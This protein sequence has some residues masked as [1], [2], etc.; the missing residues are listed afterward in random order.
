MRPNRCPPQIYLLMSSHRPP[1]RFKIF[2]TGDHQVDR[3][4]LCWLK[5]SPEKPAAKR[6]NL[7]FPSTNIFLR[8]QL[9]AQIAMK[10]WIYNAWIP[11]TIGGN[12]SGK[13]VT[14]V[15]S[16]F[17]LHLKANFMKRRRH[18]LSVNGF[19]ILWKRKLCEV[20]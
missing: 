10:C 17:F 12:G 6:S 19:T 1:S 9:W 18:P 7:L 11:P 13:L 5:Q 20:Y 14:A 4:R 3:H 8:S 2:S 16:A 15:S